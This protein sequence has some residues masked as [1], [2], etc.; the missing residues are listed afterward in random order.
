METTVAVLDVDALDYYAG[1]IILIS[2]RSKLNKYTSGSN[3]VLYLRFVLASSGLA[4]LRITRKTFAFCS[5]PLRRSSSSL[6]GV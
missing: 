3:H 2:F 5:A 4:L 1:H 6:R